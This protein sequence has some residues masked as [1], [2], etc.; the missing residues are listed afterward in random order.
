V[1]DI[2]AA[3]KNEPPTGVDTGVIDD[4]ESRLSSA[5]RAAEAAA[6][7]SAHRPSGRADQS[8]HDQ[9]CQEKPH[10][11]W[12]FRAEH[13]EHSP[14]SQ[15]RR[16][17]PSELQ[18]LTAPVTFAVPNTN[19]ELRRPSKITADP[20]GPTVLMVNGGLMANLD[21]ARL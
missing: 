10:G 18:W 1:L 21:G 5:R 15:C 20:R 3:N 13:V 14:Y 4:S 6:A 11:E 16:C 2:V 9:E 12:H 17:R 19:K 7:E 8:Q